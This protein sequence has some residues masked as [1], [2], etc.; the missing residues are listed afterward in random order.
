MKI[1]IACIGSRGDVQPFIALALGLRERGHEVA[2]MAPGSYREFIGAFDIPLIPLSLDPETSIRDPKILGPL[3]KGNILRFIRA[4]QKV[5]ARNAPVVNRELAL[6][7]AEFDALI[8]SSLAALSVLSIAEKYGKKAGFVFL[9]MPISPTSQF[10]HS[11]FGHLHFGMLNKSSYLINQL[12]WLTIRKMH[13]RFRER[14]ELPRKNVLGTLLKANW[15]TLYPMSKCLQPEPADWPSNTHVTGFLK[16][17]EKYR[18][19]YVREQPSPELDQW[20]GE[21]DKP[22]Y[23]GFGSIP[24]PDTEKWKRILNELLDRTSYRILFCK[25]WTTIEGLPQHPHLFVAKSIDHSNILPRCKAAVIHGGMGTTASV[26]EAGIPMLVVSVLADQPYNG[27]MAER[28]RIGKH[29]PF[30][31][32]NFSRLMKALGEI[33]SDKTILNARDLGAQISKEDGLGE[34]VSFVEHYFQS[35][36]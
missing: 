14:L 30:K 5:T 28:K 18:M 15:L 31:K 6:A 25:G 4:L 33:L 13:L 9:S 7:S 29:L 27:R 16:I 36:E 1:G 20:M 23:I 32:I 3:K 21:G 26:M 24:I 11:V 10:P 19:A 12:V 35:A 8:A 17:P 34:C 22:V 2:L